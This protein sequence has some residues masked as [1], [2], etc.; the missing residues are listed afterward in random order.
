[1][2]IFSLYGEVHRVRRVKDFA[3]VFFENRGDAL[4]AME[5]T[6]DTEIDGSI[7]HVALA[8]PQT[9]EQKQR[10]AERKREREMRQGGGRP[11]SMDDSGFFGGPPPP[12]PGWGPGPGPGPQRMSRDGMPPPHDAYFDEFGPM[13]PPE[14]EYYDEYYEPEYGFAEEG[15]PPGMMSPMGPRPMM[16]PRGRGGRGNFGARPPPPP[17]PPP[18]RGRGHPQQGARSYDGGPAMHQP[19]MRGGRPPMTP[20]GGGR[21][22]GRGGPPGRGRGTPGGFG[23]RGMQGGGPRGRGVKRPA[24]TGMPDTGAKRGRP[25]DL[26]ARQQPLPQQSTIPRLGGI[27]GQGQGGMAVQG[28]GGMAVQGRGRAQPPRGQQSWSGSTMNQQPQQQSVGFGST[29]GFTSMQNAPY[30]QLGGTTFGQSQRPT[31]PQQQQRQPSW[32]SEYSGG[33]Q[34]Q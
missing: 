2:Q 22:R 28:Q 33:G 21:G 30:G 29:T 20:R 14:E 4:Q 23:N 16:G 18:P 25:P 13:G 10:N 12:G 8:K 3:F 7:I 17:P 9:N 24:P 11:G 19:M 5:A 15:Y 27:L 26:F 34:L 32:Y 31:A 6:N 1:M